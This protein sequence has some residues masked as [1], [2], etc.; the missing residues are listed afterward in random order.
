MLYRVRA[1]E[2]SRVLRC[3]AG[4]AVQ[5]RVRRGKAG[6]AVDRTARRLDRHGGLPAWLEKS[7]PVLLILLV[8][9]GPYRL[10]FPYRLS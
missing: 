8:I 4:S 5:I 3:Y 10:P 9:D 6:C 1:V 2:L 7:I